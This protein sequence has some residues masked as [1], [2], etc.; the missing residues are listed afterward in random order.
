MKKLFS[1]ATLCFVDSKNGISN[2]DVPNRL[3]DAR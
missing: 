1:P 2:E 3:V